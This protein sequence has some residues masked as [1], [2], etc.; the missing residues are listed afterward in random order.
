MITQVV[1]CLL[2]LPGACI[3]SLV[4]RINGPGLAFAAKDLIA[5]DM[6]CKTVLR[7]V[8]GSRNCNGTTSQNRNDE[9]NRREYRDWCG[10]DF[11]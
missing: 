5:Q 6:S 10:Y 1:A 3:G 4:R 11:K 7:A 2:D 8:S 9:G